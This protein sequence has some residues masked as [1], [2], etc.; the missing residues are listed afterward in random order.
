[1]SFPFIVEISL[2]VVFEVVEQGEAVVDG[3]EAAVVVEVTPMEIEDS[4]V[5]ALLEAIV[6]SSQEERYE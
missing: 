5:T 3:E 6:I 2:I 1:M 4:T